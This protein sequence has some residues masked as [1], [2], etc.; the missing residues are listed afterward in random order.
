MYDLSSMGLLK[1]PN[2]KVEDKLIEYGKNLK[3]KIEATKH[4]KDK[5]YLEEFTFQ[6]TFQTK[7]RKMT[8]GKISQPTSNF[9]ERQKAFL[10]NVAKKVDD[11]KAELKDPDLKELT[12]KPAISKFAQEN[13]E[14][15]SVKDLYKWQEKVDKDKKRKLE[16]K[17]I[18]EKE[19]IE[20]SLAF[21]HK[22]SKNSEV[23]LKNKKFNQSVLNES[24]LAERNSEDILNT[25][26]EITKTKEK[27]VEAEETHNILDKVMNNNDITQEEELDLWPVKKV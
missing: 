18:K 7:Q 17:E 24:I 4:E 2:N 9:Y 15:R 1:R 3:H 19:E 10:K 8:Q 22:T 23:I 12:F 14:K 5:K 21:K 6:P 27:Q 13:F 11:K 26:R 16:Q 25:G 20:Q